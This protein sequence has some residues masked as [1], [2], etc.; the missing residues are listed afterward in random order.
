[1]SR[2]RVRVE[3][4]DLGGMSRDAAWRE[5]AQI[6][7][8]QAVCFPGK[9]MDVVYAERI[10]RAFVENEVWLVRSPDDEVVG[11]LHGFSEDAEFVGTKVC[12]MRTVVA[13]LPEWRSAIGATFSR[14]GAAAMVRVAFRTRLRGRLPLLLPRFG[15]PATYR[16]MVRLLSRLVPSPRSNVD[17]YLLALRDAAITHFQ[18]ERVEGRE[19]VVRGPRL[20]MSAGERA[21]W[22]AHTSPEVRYFIEQ[23]PR[24]GEGE[25]LIGVVPMDWT[26]LAQAPL[27]ASLGLAREW[28]RR[29]QGRLQSPGP[30]P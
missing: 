12:V 14:L 15:T 11:F 4:L 8:V 27:R 28:F 7:P 24:F 6:A 17:P 3:H 25:C 18:L 26:D 13:A 23:C 20:A 29:R 9:S 5:M 16:T 21:H 19:H 22:H 10:D 1:M 2:A 30:R